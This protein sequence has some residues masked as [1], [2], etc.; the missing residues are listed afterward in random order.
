M[1]VQAATAQG[2]TV[3]GTAGSAHTTPELTWGLILALQRHICAEDRAMKAGGWQTTVG[4]GL[5]GTTLGLLGLGR[6]GSEVARIGQAFRVN[7]IAW[8]ENLTAERAAGLGA[9]CVGKDE[10][11]RQSDVLSIHT[12]L[13]GRTRGLVGAREL[14]LMKPSAVLVNTSRGPIVD[15]AA[16]VEALRNRTIAGAGLDVFDTEP[17]PR[18]HPLRSLDNAVLT[19]HLGYVTGDTFAVMYPQ[20]LECVQAWLA[21]D[22]VRTISG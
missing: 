20:M 10:L 18:S 17:L 1:D 21:G 14:G 2:V 13:S 6:L 9:A 3:C 19:P 11:F 16:L 8:S 4:R 12:L 5:A 22:P 15:E 7:L